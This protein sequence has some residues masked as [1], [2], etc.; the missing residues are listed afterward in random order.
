MLF[1]RWNRNLTFV[2]IWTNASFSIILMKRNWSRQLKQAIPKI[3]EV[4]GAALYPQEN[5]ISALM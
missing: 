4:V 2:W 5:L 1:K 3:V